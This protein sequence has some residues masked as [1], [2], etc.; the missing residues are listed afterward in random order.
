MY[1]VGQEP[2]NSA[3]EEGE[4]DTRYIEKLKRHSKYSSEKRRK[5]ERKHN[6]ADKA[7]HKSSSSSSKIKHL[8]RQ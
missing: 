5:L 1:K 4:E 2:T 8:K 3:V 6:E 7:A